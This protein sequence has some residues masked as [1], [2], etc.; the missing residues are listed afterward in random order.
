MRIL[1]MKFA[2]SDAARFHALVDRRGDSEC[3]SWTGAVNNDGYGRFKVG[4]RSG[5]LLLAHRVAYALHQQTPRC[6]FLVCHKCDNPGCCNPAHLF[7]GRPRRNVGDMIAKGRRGRPNAKLSREG[8]AE[9]QRLREGGA[10]ADELALRFGVTPDRVR[11]LSPARRRR[12]RT[13]ISLI[14]VDGSG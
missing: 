1:G 4:G 5:K 3:W 8:T 9:V 10:R 7:M 6:G 12:R 11:A 2:E 13:G 14:R